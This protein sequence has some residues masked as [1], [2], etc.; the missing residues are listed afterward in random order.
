VLVAMSEIPRKLSLLS[1][2]WCEHGKEQGH[3]ISD[4]EDDA[5]L[6]EMHPPIPKKTRSSSPPVEAFRGFERF[7]IRLGKDAESV[8]VGINE[9]V[10]TLWE[11]DSGYFSSTNSSRGKKWKVEGCA[12]CETVPRN[13]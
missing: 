9:P 8:L 5:E 13:R 12:R 11:T 7:I 1:E 3:Y 4:S 2:R 10:I 6:A